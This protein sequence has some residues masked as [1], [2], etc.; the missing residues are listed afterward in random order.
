MKK[1]VNFVGG[2]YYFENFGD[3]NSKKQD[4][5]CNK[6]Y[7]MKF[8]HSYPQL[9]SVDQPLWCSL[10]KKIITKSKDQTA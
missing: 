8:L 9:Q 4:M 10:T 6:E 7:S 3:L 1:T 5:A 2:R